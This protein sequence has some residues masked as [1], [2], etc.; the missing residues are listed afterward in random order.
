M[1]DLIVT[2][3]DLAVSS[4]GRGFYVLD[5]IEPLR[6]YTTTMASSSDPVLFKPSVVY[7]SSSPAAIQYLLKRPAQNVRIEILDAK[8]Q[9]IRTYPDSAALAAANEGRGGAAPAG[10]RGRGGA[11]DSANANAQPAGGGGGR[12]RGNAGNIPGRGAGLNSFNW[13]Q[14]YA[15]AVSFPNMILWG[16]STTGPQAP[17]GNYTVRL[18][19]DGK[20]LTQPIVV[21][22]NPW[23]SATDADLQAQ[24]A[25][26]IQLRDKVS[27]ANNAVIQIRNIKQQVADRLGKSQD[28]QLKATG[29]KLTKDLSDVE[30]EIYQVRNQSGQDPLNFPIKVNNRLAAL[31]GVVSNTDNKPIASAYPIF[32]DLRGELKVQTDRLAKVLKDDL[33]GFNGDAK[34]LGLNPVVAGKPVVF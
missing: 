28:P 8:G 21:R 2:D 23:H 30:G 5:N 33:D 7:R 17:P 34:R 12:G 15:D 31:L 14:R 4:H 1:W 9:V 13:D 25:L 29:D 19:A 18:T 27:E 24:F 6:E 22:R 3:H 10:G 11:P 20:T 26:A 32:T 16:G